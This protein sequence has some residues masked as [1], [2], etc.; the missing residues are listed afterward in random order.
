MNLLPRMPSVDVAW[1]AIPIAFLIYVILQID[2]RRKDSPTAGDDQLGIKTVAA[3]LSVVSTLLFALGLQGFLAAL[4]TF[5]GVG[6][7]LK[8]AAPSLLVGAVGVV[9]MALVLFPRTNASEFPKA[10]RLAAG[11][12]ALVA[13]IAMLPALAS[14]LSALLEWPSG[15]VVGTEFATALT[16]IVIFAGGFV[17]LGKLSGLKMPEPKAKPMGPPGGGVQP[18]APG[19]MQQAPGGMQQPGGMQPP[20]G[21]MQQPPQGYPGQPPAGMQA[22][23][24]YP[25]AGMQAPQGFA[26][27]G[28]T[29]VPGQGQGGWPQG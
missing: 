7:R 20:P 11:V 16:A 17:V 1:S 21:G 15:K 27:S 6:A 5:D 13:G 8:A 18:P 2:A 3:T 25:P 28:G 10:K 24:G 29:Q 14:F 4:F 19:G 23:Q 22:P 9:A 12:V 26:P